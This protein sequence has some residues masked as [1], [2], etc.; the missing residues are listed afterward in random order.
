MEEDHQNIKIVDSSVCYNACTLPIS[1]NTIQ[2]WDGNVRKNN[3]RKMN[4][5]M[6]DLIYECSLSLLLLFKTQAKQVFGKTGIIV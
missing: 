1:G 6:S 3:K 5:K 4:V 2:T